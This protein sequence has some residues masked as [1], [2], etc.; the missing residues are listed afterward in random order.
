LRGLLYFTCI[1][2]S[3]TVLLRISQDH[4]HTC[5]R[6]STAKVYQISE[7]EVRR[8][9][10]NCHTSFPR[11]TVP[12]CHE[13]RQR[14]S[15][16]TLSRPAFAEFCYLTICKPAV[17]HHRELDFSFRMR[18]KRFVGR[19]LPGPAVMLTVYRL[20]YSWILGKNPSTG[21][22]TKRREV[23]RWR[24]GKGRRG[25]RGKEKDR[26]DEIPYRGTSLF[27]LP[28]LLRLYLKPHLVS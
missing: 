1:S 25:R 13:D 10:H 24:K 3:S 27:P 6:L 26:N 12:V 23:K 22:D 15:A 2:V 11:N 4:R 7:L 14:P 18:Q 21:S 19:A 28:A 8:Y 5:A 17:A 16:R 20:L 9:C